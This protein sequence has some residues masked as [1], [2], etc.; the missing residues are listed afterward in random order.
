MRF[1][2]P[3]M[4]TSQFQESVECFPGDTGMAV[5]IQKK[6]IVR[7]DKPGHDGLQPLFRYNF[8]ERSSMAP[9]VHVDPSGKS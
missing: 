1:L 4:K 6:K 2:D 7:F 5:W 3:Y 9:Q 8:I